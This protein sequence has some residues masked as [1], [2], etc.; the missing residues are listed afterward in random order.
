MA[1]HAVALLAQSDA[2]YSSAFIAGS[3]NT[4]A[5]F[6]RRILRRLNEAGIIEAREGRGGGRAG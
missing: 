4:H 2:G 6:L 3:V 5:V 1:V